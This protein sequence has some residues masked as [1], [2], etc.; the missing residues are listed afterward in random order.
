VSEE[1]PKLNHSVQK[2]IS[3]LRAVAES[4]GTSV[5]AL[6][7]D[8]GL[9]RATAL[10][11]IQ[12][13]ER[14]RF[15]LRVPGEDRVLLGPELLRLAREGD[16]GTLLLEI[17]RGPL[18]QLSETLRETVTLT[19]VAADG[20]LDLIYQ[21]DGPHHLVPRSWIGQSFPLHASSSGKVL[22]ATYDEERLAQFLQ[23][24]LVRLTSATITTERG[25][26]REL[27]QVR[28]RGYA[29]TC[30]ELEEGLSGVSVGVAP[31]G[32]ALLG[33]INLS[34]LTQRFDEIRRRRIA[35]QMRAVAHDIEDALG[36]EDRSAI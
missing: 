34:G 33:I 28:S 6:A 32:G 15:L 17:A 30:D 1:S 5:S 7:R 13:L 25:L 21:V 35:E 2:A 8:V 9:P 18:S 27:E 22:L 26:R 31:D 24:P 12:T 29:V 20:G 11:M 16:V 36:H 4:G 3:L 23:Q 19:V 14:E 10:R